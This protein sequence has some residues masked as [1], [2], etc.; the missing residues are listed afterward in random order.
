MAMNQ[1]RNLCW[2]T[3]CLVQLAAVLPAAGAVAA[4]WPQWRGPNRDGISQETGLL[5]DWPK[6]GPPQVWR[7][8]GVGGAPSTR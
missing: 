6:A 4:D 5:Q 8:S 1:F 2:C 3:L 7:V